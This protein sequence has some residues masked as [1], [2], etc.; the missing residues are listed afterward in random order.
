MRLKPGGR[1]EIENRLEILVQI[2]G[3]SLKLITAS[4]GL[5]PISPTLLMIA[6]MAASIQ[7]VSAGSS[8]TGGLAF[9]NLRAVFSSP[10]FAVNSPSLLSTAF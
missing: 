9:L 3:K 2:F 6:L 1:Q 8:G 10:L 7:R 5:V 4:D